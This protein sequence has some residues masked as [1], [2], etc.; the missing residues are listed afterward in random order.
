MTDSVAI[1]G[2]GIAGMCTALALARRGFAVTVLERDSAPPDGDA[3]RAFFDWP[4]RGASQFRHPHAFLGLMCNLLQDHYPDLLEDFYAAGARRLSFHEMLSKE[5]EP[6]YRPAPGDEKLWVLLCRRA[7]IETVL[8]RYVERMQNIRI[9]NGVTIDGVITETHDDALSVRG[10]RVR[11]DGVAQFGAEIR[12][13][14]VVDASGRASK[15]PRW[16]GDLGVAIPEENDD[17]EIVYYT[18]HYQLRPGVSE[19]PRGGEDRSAGDL[20]Y[21][22]F[23]VFPGDKGSFAI[24]VCLHARE[25]ELREA[26]KDGAKF[27]AMCRRIPGLAP[28]VKEGAVDATTHP[29]GI[30]DIRAVWR[31]FV[32]DGKPLVRNFFAVGDAALRTNPLYGRGCS[33]GI[34]HAHMLAEILSGVADPTARAVEFDRRTEAELRPIFATSLAE[35]RNG[36]RRAIAS[37]EGRLVEPPDSLKKWFGLAF[38]DALAAASRHNLYVLRGMMRTVNLL[39]KPGAFLEDRRT[40]LIVMSYM[41]RGRSRNAAARI[42]RGPSRNEMLAVVAKD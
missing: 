19:P 3:D 29:F 14:V 25:T 9:V 7:T 35:D 10:L 23:G 26:V 2:S 39:E 31:H 18:R 33:T 16:F 8:R 30:G 12:A 6:R 24:I 27:D 17:A 5:I 20:G 40:Q 42:V 4:R 41:L 28:W 11:S 22:K 1:V 36:I 34:L 37:H 13:D 38:G 21:V 32:V 15:F